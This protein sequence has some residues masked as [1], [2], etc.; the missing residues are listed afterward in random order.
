[1]GKTGAKKG[2]L[3]AR[4]SLRKQKRGK[5]FSVRREDPLFQIFER[6]LYEFEYDSRDAFIEG[7]VGEYIQFLVSEES[8]V[9]LN[10]H[11]DLVQEAV[12]DEVSDMLVRRIYGCLKVEGQDKRTQLEIEILEENESIIESDVVKRRLL[13]LASK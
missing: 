10:G 2:T 1:M 9:M 4:T 6:R 12:A 13:K 11:K 3:R 8:C 7:V 5:R